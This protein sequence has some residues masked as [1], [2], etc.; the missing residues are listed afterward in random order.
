MSPKPET[1]NRST[2]SPIAL[3]NKKAP[4]EASARD[5]KLRE[6]SKQ[7]EKKQSPAPHVVFVAY[8]MMG[9]TPV[10]LPRLCTCAQQRAA[11]SWC[12]LIL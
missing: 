3:K 7:L 5:P 9:G 12:R 11:I 6:E 8:E 4:Y 1:L 2:R 10:K